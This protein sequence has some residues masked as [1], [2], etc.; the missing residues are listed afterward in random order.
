MRLDGRV[1]AE[2]SRVWAR[3]S[4]VTDPAH[5]AAAKQ[6]REQFQRP[7]VV[8]AADDLTRDVADYDRVFGQT[9]TAS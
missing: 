8:T 3:G 7:R 9:G 5:V 2:H 1:V 4:T 6:L